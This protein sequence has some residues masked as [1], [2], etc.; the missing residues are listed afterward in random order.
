MLFVFYRYSK[1]CLLVLLIAFTGISCKKFVEVPPGAGIIE[2]AAVFSN[3]ETA[4]SAVA[5]LH[6]RMRAV[7]NAMTNGGLSL[8]ASLSSDDLYPTSSVANNDAFYKNTLLSNNSV[9]YSNFWIFSYRNIYQANS[10]LE[11]LN[12]STAL[13]DSVKHHL[14]GEV[15]LIRALHYFY[16]VNLFGKVPYITGTDYR[17]NAT[18]ERTGVSTVYSELIKEVTMAEQLLAAYY[19]SANRA[20]ANQYMADALL[21]RLYLY[22]GNYQAAADRASKVIDAGIYHL[23]D[24]L[25]NVFQVGSNEV[26]WQISSDVVN[27]AEGMS[28][29]PASATARPNFALTTSLLSAFEPND[30]R[31]LLWT[32]TNLNNGNAYTFPHKYKQRTSASITEYNVV[33]RLAELYL[34]RAE[35]RTLLND[36][37]GALEDINLIRER[38]AL[39]PIISIANQQDLLAA[40]EKENRSE[41]FCE[42]GHRWLDLKRWGQA[43]SILGLEKGTNWQPTDALYPIPFNELT[44]NLMLTQNPGY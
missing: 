14:A 39:D 33:C 44:Y 2:T 24:D 27:T 26:I 17:V 29:V 3:D 8:Y 21:A 7:N 43:D 25:S 11:G 13:T 32:K 40:I 31:K 1:S 19:L 5:G 18:K 42:W 16:L 34:I 6:V 15:K 41:Y 35:A 12:Q 23:E 9:V 20:R 37:T 10:I 22:T 38:A 30:K 36:F 4:L 28:F